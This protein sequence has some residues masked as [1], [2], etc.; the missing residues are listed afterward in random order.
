[1]GIGQVVGKRIGAWLA[2][3]AEYGR[4]IEHVP[5]EQLV[6]IA[7]LPNS[8]RHEIEM[9]RRLK[10]AVEALTAELVSFRTSSDEAAGKLERLTKWLIGFTIV[11]VVL[12]LA[13]A[14]LTAVLAAKG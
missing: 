9:Q 4:A 2:E 8:P 6:G 12:T 14:G 10:V 5:D 7:A 1:V 3:R 11:L 13:V